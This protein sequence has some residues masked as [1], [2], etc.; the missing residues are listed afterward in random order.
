[1]EEEEEKVD[2]LP[3]LS[4]SLAARKMKRKHRWWVHS[5]LK[6]RKQHGLYHHLVN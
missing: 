6:K 2:H 3:L 1:M 4:V 5:I